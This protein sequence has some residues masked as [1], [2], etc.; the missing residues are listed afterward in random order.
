MKDLLGI[1]Q[2][3]VKIRIIQQT[4]TDPKGKN[5][6]VKGKIQNTEGREDKNMR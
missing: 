5:P 4:Q 6:K 2:V 3:R 1:S